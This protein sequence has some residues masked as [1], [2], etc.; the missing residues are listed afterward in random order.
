MK[1]RWGRRRSLGVAV[2]LAALTLLAPTGAAA[3]DSDLK[4]SALFRLHGSNG[5][6]ILVLATSERADNRGDVAIIVGRRGAGVIYTAP[7]LVSPTRFEADL[8]ALGRISLDVVSSGA[9]KRLRPSCGGEAVTFEPD[10]Y[11][12]TFEFRGEEGFTDATAT[13]IPEYGR[14]FLDL[15][16]AGAFRGESWGPGSPGARLQVRMGKGPNRTSLQVNQNRPGARTHFKAEVVEKRGRVG[17]QRFVEGR[18]PSG[19]FD[20]DPLL[21]AA[22]LDPPAPFSGSAAF[23]RNASPANRWTGDLS[24]DFPGRS[25]VPLTR[26]GA[27]VSLVHAQI[28]RN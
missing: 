11:R 15:G 22:T 17:I 24:V 27:R 28:S 9:E 1:V 19:A 25:D 26:P 10:V 21:R 18:A 14:F 20:F 2:G 5:Y 13:Q 12:G 16:C 7:A 8:G 3:L 6:S 4:G 23:H